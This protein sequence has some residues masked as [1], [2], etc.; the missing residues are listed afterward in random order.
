VKKVAKSAKKAA[1]KAAKKTVA[2]KAAKKAPAKKAAAKKAA[3]KAPAKKA[4]AKKAAKKAA[5]EVIPTPHLD[6]EGGR[7]LQWRPLRDSGAGLSTAGNLRIPRLSF[8]QKR[9]CITRPSLRPSFPRP[10]GT[11]SRQMR[12]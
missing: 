2:K 6:W 4:A 9:G 8:H 3:K 5:E 11:V 10:G 7:L 1:K 12:G